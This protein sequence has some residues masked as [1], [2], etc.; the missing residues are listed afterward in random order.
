MSGSKALLS[1]RPF[2]CGVIS[3]NDSRFSNLFFPLS[4]SKNI[5]M[6]PTKIKYGGPQSVKT[7]FVKIVKYMEELRNSLRPLPRNIRASFQL[8]VNEHGDSTHFIFKLFFYV[9]E[10][11]ASRCV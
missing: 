7:N 4:G 2:F 9:I 8:V 11:L 10:I 1:Q 6:S 3:Y 5:R